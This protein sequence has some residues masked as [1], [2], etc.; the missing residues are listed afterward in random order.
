MFLGLPRVVV[1]GRRMR[2]DIRLKWKKLPPS[3]RVQLP[4]LPVK[5]SFDKKLITDE[6]DLLVILIG[7]PPEW[8]IDEKLKSRRVKPS[9]YRVVM[10]RDKT[11]SEVAYIHKEDWNKVTEEA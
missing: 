2:Q 5:C 1:L 11:R 10:S 4:E 8:K 9:R 7:D 6:N 3:N